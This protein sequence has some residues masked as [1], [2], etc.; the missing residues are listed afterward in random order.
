MAVP[1]LHAE[2]SIALWLLSATSAPNTK[3]KFKL[4]FETNKRHT[5]SGNTEKLFFL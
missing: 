3:V 4:K 2:R 5:Y 1:P